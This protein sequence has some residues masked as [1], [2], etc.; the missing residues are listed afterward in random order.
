MIGLTTHCNANMI[1]KLD[2]YLNKVLGKSQLMLLFLNN[3][4]KQQ[5]T[6]KKAKIKYFMIFKHF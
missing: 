2:V 3:K 4:I 5:K 1:V 6:I